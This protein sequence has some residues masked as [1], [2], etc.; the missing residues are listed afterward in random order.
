M[1]E[2]MRYAHFC[3]MRNMLRWHDRY[4]PVSLAHGSSSSTCY[5]APA[6]SKQAQTVAE[7]TSSLLPVVQTMSRQNHRISQTT[8]T[9]LHTYTHTWCKTLI[10]SSRTFFGLCTNL[11][12]RRPCNLY[13]TVFHNLASCT[14]MYKYIKAT[15]HQ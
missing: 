13:I 11:Q 2:N 1:W 10:T 12:L 7:T 14:R 5:R 4:K 15:Q 8:M 3:N 9:T 6:A